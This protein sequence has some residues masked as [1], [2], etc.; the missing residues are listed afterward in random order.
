MG[1][2]V[3]VN[4][5]IENWRWFRDRVTFSMVASRERQHGLRVPRIRR[6]QARVLPIAA[7]FG[8]NA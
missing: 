8:G 6:F 3:I 4:I 1:S 2:N 7:I 5:S